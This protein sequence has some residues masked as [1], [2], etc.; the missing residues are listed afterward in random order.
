[1]YVR[2]KERTAFEEKLAE[3]PVFYHTDG[4]TFASART[5]ANEFFQEVDRVSSEH[6][7][8]YT[9]WRTFPTPE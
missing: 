9:A 1:M 5:K 4:E 7:Y 3:E 6:S 2:H 8:D